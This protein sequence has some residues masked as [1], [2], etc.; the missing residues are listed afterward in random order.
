MTFKRIRS[1][2]AERTPL[3]IRVFGSIWKYRMQRLGCRTCT[4]RAVDANVEHRRQELYGGLGAC[5]LG[6][7][8]RLDS[9]KFNFLP[10]LDPNWLNWEVF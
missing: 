4:V 10:S 5:S 7:F 3:L 6:N 8:Y 1:N 2:R 9:L